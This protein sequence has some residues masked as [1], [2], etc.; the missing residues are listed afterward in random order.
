MKQYTHSF[1]QVT[2]L[3]LKKA[4]DQTYQ[5]ISKFFLKHRMLPSNF[6]VLVEA[7]TMKHLK[8]LI[9]LAD[10][11]EAA[12]ETL[13]ILEFTIGIGFF[14]FFL[15][16]FIYFFLTA[17]AF[18]SVVVVSGGYS[19]VVICRLSSSMVC[20]IFPDQGFEPVPPALASGFLSISRQVPVFAFDIGQPFPFFFFLMEVS[21][22]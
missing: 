19:F 20:E 9:Y 13:A 4:K 14:F 18:L 10:N 7:Q 6:I 15:R 22:V 1:L 16:I 5:W 11:W 21:E 12:H 8:C 17:W 2:G 3:L